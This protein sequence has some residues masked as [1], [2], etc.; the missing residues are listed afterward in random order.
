MGA[1]RSNPITAVVL[2]LALCTI[3]LDAHAW[4]L[5][6]HVY[7]TEAPAV[8]PLAVPAFVLAVTRFPQWVVA[9]AC[10]PDLVLFGRNCGSQAFEGNH[11]WRMA[12]RLLDTAR[13]DEEKAAA[14]GYASHLFIDVIAHNH[15]VPSHEQR[16]IHVPRFTHVAAEW[17]MDVHLGERIKIWPAEA[18][19]ALSGAL[20]GYVSD[21]FSC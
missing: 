14:V 17:A 7:F 10:L 9:G 19:Q 6:T 21:S 8:L 3:A 11:Q 1:V 2:V 13:S 16:W 5:G 20:T 15:F 18:L 4:G 12:H